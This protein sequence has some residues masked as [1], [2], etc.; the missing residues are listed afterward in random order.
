MHAH[1]LLSAITLAVLT[2]STAAYASGGEP[3][4]AAQTAAKLPGKP[5][6]FFLRNVTGPQG[7]A[8]TVVDNSTLIMQI[9][10]VPAGKAYLIKLL[11]P[12]FDLRLHLNL[13]FEDT[14]HT[15][16]ICDESHAN[17][18]VPQYTPPRV[19][20]AAVHELTP[21]EVAGLMKSSGK[22]VAGKGNQ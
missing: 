15:G 3:S 14:D 2:A 20:I 6:C 11:S 5:A 4:A 19:P 8:W 7:A 22:N 21:D 12:V 1:R 13:G 18:I 9:P 16:R 17:L 10:S